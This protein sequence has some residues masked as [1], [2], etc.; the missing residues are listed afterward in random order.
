MGNKIKENYRSWYLDIDRIDSLQ[1]ISE[2]LEHILRLAILAPSGHNAQPW[3]FKIKENY[4]EVYKNKEKRL[5]IGDPEDRLMLISIGCAIANIK[6]AADYYG[7]DTQIKYLF[8][9]DLVA[10]IFLTKKITFVKQEKNLVHYILTRSTN[11]DKYFKKEISNDFFVEVTELQKQFNDKVNISWFSDVFSKKQIGEAAAFSASDV[12]DQKGFLKELG[13]Y[14]KN[15]LTKSKWGIPAFGMSIPTIPSFIVPLIVRF[16]NMDKINK[17]SNIALFEIYTPTIGVITA[18]EDREM[19]WVL[20]GE[21]YELIALIAEKYKMKTSVW[22]AP[23]VD[24][25][26]SLK[27][28]Q[29]LSL[30]NKVE[31]IFRIGYPSVTQ[32]HS[33]RYTLDDVLIKN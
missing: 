13:K 4:I 15:N 12:M 26:W 10:K 8:G 7:F 11:R 33:P 17:K 2:W 1:N 23:V 25:P 18:S 30:D 21:L 32:P 31:F 5:E 3:L 9:D 27:I 24:R 22:G 6:V 29:N 28:K 20:T 16:F 14:I 19:S